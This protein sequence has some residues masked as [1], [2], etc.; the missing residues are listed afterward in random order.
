MTVTSLSGTLCDTSGCT[1]GLVVYTGAGLSQWG[2]SGAP[3]FAVSP[4]P[5]FNGAFIRGSH[6][7]MA[8]SAM[9]AENYGVIRDFVGLSVITS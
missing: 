9:Y 3:F 6:V 5:A 4:D 2:D 7:G 1:S 8:G